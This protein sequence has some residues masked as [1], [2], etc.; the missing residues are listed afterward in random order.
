MQQAYCP[1][2]PIGLINVQPV[3]FVPFTYFS[4]YLQ[5]QA[6]RD[7][8]QTEWVFHVNGKQPFGAFRSVT[9]NGKRIIRM[10]FSIRNFAYHD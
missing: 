2:L 6:L 5:F 8:I 3:N 7:L 10:G 1:L 9:P 4:F